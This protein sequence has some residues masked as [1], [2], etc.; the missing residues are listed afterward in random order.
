MPL[1]VD[2]PSTGFC[3]LNSNLIPVNNDW[4]EV[5][6]NIPILSCPDG[7]TK[8]HATYNG[9]G[10]KQADVNLLAYPLKEITNPA[11]IKKD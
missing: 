7:V 9:E 4:L 1:R 5:F 8:E 6:N 11:A 2:L 10:F 3:H